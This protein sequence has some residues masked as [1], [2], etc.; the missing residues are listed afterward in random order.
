MWSLIL[1]KYFKKFDEQSQVKLPIHGPNSSVFCHQTWQSSDN[2]RLLYGHFVYFFFCK[3]VMFLIL[4]WS[5]W[6][7]SWEN[8]KNFTVTTSSHSSKAILTL[9]TVE[10]FYFQAN[11]D[12]NARC[13]DGNTPLHIACCRGLIGMVA[14]LMTAGACTDIENEEIPPE[15]GPQQGAE[16]EEGEEAL[17]RCRRGLQPRDYA[18]GK[19]RLRVGCLDFFFFQT[20]SLRGWECLTYD[21]QKWH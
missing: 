4:N 21:L 7:Q 12:V 13:F 5:N 6:F 16:T 11:A 14:L 9:K 17:R 10:L 20:R 8:K 1:F 2:E 18:A 15:H 3:T 19:D